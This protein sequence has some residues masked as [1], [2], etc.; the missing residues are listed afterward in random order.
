MSDYKK[1]SV[2]EEASALG[3][4][5]AGNVK[6]AAGAVTGNASLKNEGAGQAASGAARQR[7]NQMM[8][9]LFRD[10]ESA[11]RAYGSVQSRGYDKDDVNL[12]MTDETRKRHFS[13]TTDKPTEL[14]DKALEGA[15]VGSAIGGTV[16]AVLA[17]I[18]AIGTSVAL[19]G[20]GLVVAGPIAAA[21]AGA[22][23]GG[24]TGG[25]VGALVGSGIPEERVKHYEEG[26]KDGGIVMGV[27][28]RT[29]E[30]AEYF[31][32]EW[33]TSKGEHIYR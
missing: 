13:D 24:L 31:E 10:R 21:L 32:N 19:P 1:D 4:R 29:D 33:K 28:P 22:G 2:S 5:T 25:L 15:G 11:E 14:G 9:G 23:A 17:A 6:E 7:S 26:L 30:D 8:T 18:A 16:G 20:I 27:N 3:Q 12:L